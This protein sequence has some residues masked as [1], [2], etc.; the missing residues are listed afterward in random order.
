MSP[1]EVGKQETEGVTFL[2]KNKH[3]L[4]PLWKCR[5]VNLYEGK[6]CRCLALSTTLLIHV[7]SWPLQTFKFMPAHVR[8]GYG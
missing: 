4:I 5:T 1:S 3:E 6:V 8:N 7:A 2:K